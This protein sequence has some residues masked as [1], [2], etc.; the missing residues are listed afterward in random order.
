MLKILLVLFP[1]LTFS[2]SPNIQLSLVANG[3]GGIVDIVSAGDTRLFIVDGKQVKIISNYNVLSTSF[4]NLSDRAYW[5]MAVAFHPNYAQNG[6]FYVKYKALDNSCVIARF[7]KDASNQD[8][9]DPSSETI[10]FSYPNNDGHE[11]GDLEF[12]KDGFL[13]TATGDGAGGGRGEPGDEFGNAQNFA[14]VKGKMLRFDI[15]SPQTNYIPAAN[16]YQYP[17]DNIPDQIIAVGL[18]NPWKFSFD[19]QTGDVWIGDVGQ[20]SYEEVSFAPFGTFENRNYGWSCYEGNMLHLTQNCPNNAVY[21]NPIIDYA[22]YNYNGG[23]PASVTGGYVYR[24]SQY[25]ALNGF[26][27]YADY[28]SGKFWLLNKLSNNSI[29]ND[30]KG[31]LLANP[32]TFGEDN[33]GELYVATF[34][35]IYKITACGTDQ[36]LSLSGQI[37]S[38]SSYYAQNSI[39]STNVIV[40][41]SKVNYYAGKKIELNVG[42]FANAG[43]VFKA[44]IGGCQ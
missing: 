6:Y 22:G 39:Q 10:I 26:Y 24:G 19:R 4:I 14:S 15:D 37:S 25:P 33:N 11:G 8:L 43:T 12:G 20:D 21:T 5:I 7:S 29:I 3:F 30:F 2:Q 31:I 41:T 16:P 44:Q 38:A 42:F 34:G 17:N 18:R 40:S 23:L 13:Y 32:T 28:N 9:A 36:D 35:S 1:F 27:C